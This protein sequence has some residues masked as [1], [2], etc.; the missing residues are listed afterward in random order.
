[1]NKQAIFMFGQP[2]AGKGIQANLLSEKLG[3]YH[4]ESSKVLEHCF[5]TES[6]DKVFN[7][8]GKDYK[9]SDEIKRWASGELTS[10]PFFV[11]LT[12]ERIKDFNF[13]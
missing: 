9:V 1:M 11:F 10:P 2:G 13:I 8:E 5:K 6:K 3:Y 4:L 12:T 7:V